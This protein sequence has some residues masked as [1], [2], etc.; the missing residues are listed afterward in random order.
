MIV[1]KIILVFVLMSIF[2]S[3]VQAEKL[4]Y[5]PESETSASYSAYRIIDFYETTFVKYVDINENE[6]Y[7][8]RVLV[9]KKNDKLLYY[10]SMIIDS[11]EHKLIPVYEVKPIYKYA[12]LSIVDLSTDH[13]TNYRYYKIPNDVADK[14]RNTNDK[15]VLVL[16][17][18][19]KLGIK[20]NL[21]DEHTNNIKSIFGLAYTD[22][23][24]Y[25]KPKVVN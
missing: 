25:W 8:V 9:N 7:W 3:I 17:L 2:S 4:G 11:Q 15:V 10:S 21:G 14:I 23:N 19:H 12:G 6:E 22:L 18:A 24:T 13:R 1:K 16:N 20:L 5:E